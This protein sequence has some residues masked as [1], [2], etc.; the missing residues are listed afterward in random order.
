MITS[1]LVQFSESL[2]E[3]ENEDCVINDDLIYLVVIEVSH[4]F[5]QH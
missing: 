2:N 4:G 1:Q 5:N 3:A